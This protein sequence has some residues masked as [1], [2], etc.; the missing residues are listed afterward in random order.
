MFSVSVK[1]PG[2]GKKV[3]LELGDALESW[4]VLDKPYCSEGCA[5][6]NALDNSD[7][8]CPVCGGRVVEVGRTSKR[9]CANDHV[10]ENR[11]GTPMYLRNLTGDEIE[12]L[13]KQ[14]LHA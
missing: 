1:C 14:G 6:E 13:R 3:P 7:A 11:N 8:D 9:R 10:W 4:L 5:N 2:C 12:L